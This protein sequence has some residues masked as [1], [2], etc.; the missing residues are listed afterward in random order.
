ML[1]QTTHASLLGRIAEGDQ[2]A[3]KLFHERYADMIRGFARRQKLQPSDCE[4]VVQDVFLALTRALPKFSYDPARGKFRGYLKTLVLHEIFRKNRQNRGQIELE[5]LEAAIADAEVATDQVW[6]EEWREY[7][8]RL[9]M[10]RIEREFEARHVQAFRLHAL[11]GRDVRYTAETVGL[12]THQV[13]KAKSRIL[14]RLSELIRE[15][16]DE[17]G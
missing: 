6:E 8:V 3:W 4:D 14:R 13:Y 16:V 7:H 11:T 15:Q 5:D 2:Q 12:S 10:A 9:A 1:S 17:E